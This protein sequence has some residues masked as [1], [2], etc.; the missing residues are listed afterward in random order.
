MENLIIMA[1]T[2]CGTNTFVPGSKKTNTE[3]KKN[4]LEH[5]VSTKVK[6]KKKK[7]RKKNITIEI[8]NP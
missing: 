8:V 4:K 6:D 2:P 7:L 1:S 5:F 3:R